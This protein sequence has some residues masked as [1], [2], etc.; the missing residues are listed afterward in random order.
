MMPRDSARRLSV[1]NAL[2]RRDLMRRN[3]DDE[4]VHRGFIVVA[5]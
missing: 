1:G 2:V 5:Y 4:A 3:N